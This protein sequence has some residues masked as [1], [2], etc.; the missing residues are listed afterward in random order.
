MF[1]LILVLSLF[2]GCFRHYHAIAT[3]STDAFASQVYQMAYEKVVSVIQTAG[4]PVTDSAHPHLRSAEDSTMHERA[5]LHFS[6]YGDDSQ[7]TQLKS[8]VDVKIGRC[9]GLVMNYM[10]MALGED[11]TF[12]TITF[13]PHDE[14]CENVIGPAITTQ[15]YPKNVCILTTQGYAT[16]NLIAQPLRAFPGGGEAFVFYE[17]YNDCHISKHTN[18]ARANLVVTWP[19]GVCTTTVLGTSKAI[20][21]DSTSMTF[22]TYPNQGQCTAETA[23][24]YELSTDPDVLNCPAIVL[25]YDTFHYQ[26]LCVADGKV[27]VARVIL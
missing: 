24:A 14:D 6:F 2:C 1:K 23:E 27:E 7:C 18:L 20:S 16:I 21:C 3:T 17:N 11:A 26:T 15:N 4:T 12:V 9:S 8:I 5:T 25:P 10:P 19:M 13:I 22:N